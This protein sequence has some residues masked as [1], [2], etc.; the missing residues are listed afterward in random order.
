VKRT[1]E[2]SVRSE[3]EGEKKYLKMPVVNAMRRVLPVLCFTL[4]TTMSVFAQD[5][6]EVEWGA[7]LLLDDKEAT[8]GTVD[9]ASSLLEDAYGGGLQDDI[10][11]TETGPANLP[12]DVGV[13]VDGGLSLLLAAGAAYGVRRLR[14]KRRN[15][16]GIEN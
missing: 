15:R 7:L 1:I 11:G 13:P 2:S 9:V 3:S 14:V 8:G 16:G 12:G 10:I 6:P 5:L 4:A